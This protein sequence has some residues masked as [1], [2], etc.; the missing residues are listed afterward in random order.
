MALS[1]YSKFYY[2]WKVTKDNRYIDFNDGALRLA[3]LKLGSYTAQGLA[4][5]IVKQMNL[6][7]S[8]DFTVSFNRAT[9][10]F[11]ISSTSTFSLL[12]LTGTS[13]ALSIANIFGFNS[14][15]KTGASTYISDFAS[16]Y[17]YTTQFLLQ[18]YKDIST[19]RK[20]IDG[21]INKSASG[22]VEAVKFGDERFME[23][24]FL[25]VTNLIQENGSII[26]SNPTGLDEFIQFIE[27]A[28]EKGS[29][30]FI[31]DENNLLDFNVYVLESTET[32]TKGLNYDLIEMYDRGLAQYFRSGKLIFR[33]LE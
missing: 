2:G 5:E 1:T 10:K 25:F 21:V 15:D 9:R 27:Y 14:A 4:N 3:T 16:G 33:L 26:R 31:K 8:L 11:T 13:S 20:A 23:G 24:E 29:I 28:T 17:E 7:S 18:N 32:D 30:E 6:V 22:V 19:N 12:F